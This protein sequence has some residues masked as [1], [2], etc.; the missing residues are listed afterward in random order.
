M[1]DGCTGPLWA[2]LVF[3]IFIAVNG[4]LSAFTTA[5]R[6][7]QDTEIERKAK[8]GDG[9]SVRLMKMIDE[10]LYAV[11]SAQAACICLSM[12][13]GFAG[14]RYFEGKAAAGL[15]EIWP[16]TGVLPDVIAVLGVLWIVLVIVLSVGYLTP[17]KIAL[18]HSERTLYR[19]LPFVLF[20]MTV[21]KPVIAPVRAIS[22]LF[23]RIFRMD[24]NRDPEEVTEEE[25][26]SMVDEAHEHG[27]I[28]ENEAEMI[29]NIISFE[30]TE[31][32]DI[33]THRKNIAA[34]EGTATLKEA[35]EIILQGS[36]SRYP[37]YE[38][39]IDNIIGIIHL[40]DAVKMRMKDA[41]NDGIAVEDIPNLVREAT[42]IPE[43]RSID[44]IF[45]LMR[46][47][48]MHIVIVVDEYG[49][50]SGLITM[51]DILEEIVGSILDEYDDDEQYI[52]HSFDNSIVM[53]GLTPLDRVGEV[54]DY[55]FS[56]SAS[57]TLNGYL[58]E[59]LDHVPTPKDKFVRGKKFQFRILRVE[60]HVIK[61]VRAERLPEEKGE[62][63]CQDIQNSRT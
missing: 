57:E 25:I 37:V 19:W 27:V 21:M 54:L 18:Q 8:E 4:I 31:A 10:P 15:R 50:T 38:G 45:Q 40:K 6:N 63:A 2:C 58:T 59:L 28:K 26:I 52:Q 61:K 30:D 49:Q 36:N 23:V 39:D 62:E 11:H 60:N 22:N 5:L 35:T 3:L 29:Q 32:R 33:M 17:K 48:K 47:K 14:Y 13:A 16:G 53:D 24:P 12:A 56:G 55:D 42:I 46:S 1:E 43:T 34:I 20:T 9:K 44:S 7:V 51:E 41:S